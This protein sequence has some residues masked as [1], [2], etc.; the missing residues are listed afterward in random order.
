MPGTVLVLGPGRQV[1]SCPGQLGSPV[2]GPS[3][4]WA[5]PLPR[6]A[7]AHRHTS[8]SHLSQSWL[9]L[10]SLAFLSLP[11]LWWPCLR[12]L[13]PFVFV[14]KSVKLRSF[15]AGHLILT[16]HQGGSSLH[17]KAHHRQSGKTTVF[18]ASQPG[19]S[20]NHPPGE[21]VSSTL[22]FSTVLSLLFKIWVLEQFAECWDVARHLRSV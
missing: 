21:G 7:S 3:A 22:F 11:L 15:H 16:V 20:E 10:C 1:P 17:P 4:T 19:E 8:S 2:P 6:G 12:V 14:V 13:I 18:S 9:P 5:D